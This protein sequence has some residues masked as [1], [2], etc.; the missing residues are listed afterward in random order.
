MKIIYP[1]ALIMFLLCCKEAVSQDNC[2]TD[3]I[4]KSKRMHAKSAKHKKDM[5]RSDYNVCKTELKELTEKFSACGT[6]L[7]KYVNAGDRASAIQTIKVH[8]GEMEKTKMRLS[9]SGTLE[10]FIP[11]Y[12]KLFL[13]YCH[14]TGIL[15]QLMLILNKYDPVKKSVREISELFSSINAEDKK[16]IDAVNDEFTR[17]DKLYGLSKQ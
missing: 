8:K 6:D 16:R 9:A 14:G 2:N 5:M 1:I 15:D 4:T 12:K 7:A 3:V 10:E 13:Y 17:L 11:L